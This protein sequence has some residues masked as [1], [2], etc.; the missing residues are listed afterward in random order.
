MGAS[1]LEVYVGGNFTFV[2][3]VHAEI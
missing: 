1:E 2:P 3:V